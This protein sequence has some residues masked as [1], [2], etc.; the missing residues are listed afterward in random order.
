[1]RSDRH[2]SFANS[3]FCSNVQPVERWRMLK[4]LAIE[5]SITPHDLTCMQSRG[6]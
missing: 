6:F 3:M 1:M 2:S 4:Q 5:V